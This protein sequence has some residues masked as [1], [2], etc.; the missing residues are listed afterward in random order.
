VH[1][2]SRRLLLSVS[3]SLVAFFGVTI[4]VLDANFRDISEHSLQDLL[5]AQIVALVAASEPQANG[6]FAPLTRDLQSRLATPRSGLYAQ[7]RSA[8][9]G[10][11]IW[12]SP[13]TA[14]AEIDFGPE[15]R[16][17]DKEFRPAAKVGSE[18]VALASRGIS[19]TDEAHV[20]RDLTFS[21]AASLTPYHEQLWS[22]RRRLF[23]WFFGLA[24]ALL[25][26]LGGLLRWVLAPVRRLEREINAVE[27]GSLE[28]LGDGYPRELAG[29]ATNLNTLLL[30]ERNR[31]ARYRDTLGNLA[32]SL[33]TPLAVM[34]S[35][36]P[37]SQT[38]STG[39]RVTEIDRMTAIV[40]HQLRRAAAGGALLGQA[41]VDVGKVVGELRIA[42]LHVHGR[43][44]LLIS[45]RVAPNA[46]FVGDRGDFMELMGNLIDNAC[47]WCEQQ[48]RVS[49]RV[50]PLAPPKHRLKIIVEDDGPGISEGDRARVLQR[51]VRADESVPGHGLGLA[52]ARDTVELYGGTLTIERSDLGGA[53]ICLGLPG[54]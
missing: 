34:R 10:V 25:A 7:I 53:R 22:F 45:V 1:S 54:R 50:E 19:F 2:L 36:L 17:G 40:E 42:M 38:E 9:V 27:A 16:T 20:R 23:G 49:A 11:P 29:V 33:K 8:Q 21:V 31:L 43:K 18:G 12:N 6:V 37:K 48:V 47:K 26:T 35:T 4:V 46:Q 13:S 44:D 15:L 51:G 14:G 32:H 30:G 3:V 24:L 39:I 28:S 52:M 5:D 41:P